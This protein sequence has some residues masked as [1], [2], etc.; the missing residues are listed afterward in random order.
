MTIL[1]KKDKY[2]KYAYF[3]ALGGGCIY[4]IATLLNKICA[5][6]GNDIVLKLKSLLSANFCNGLR[7]VCA[8]E[9]RCSTMLISSSDILLTQKK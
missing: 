7:Y 2:K 5:V 4:C 8:Q 1:P 9:R 3:N 6:V